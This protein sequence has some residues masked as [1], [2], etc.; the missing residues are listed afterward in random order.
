MR[1]FTCEAYDV[2]RIIVKLHRKKVPL[3]FPN[4]PSNNF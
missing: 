1:Y 3:G 4:L 2:N